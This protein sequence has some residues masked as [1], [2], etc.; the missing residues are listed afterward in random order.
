MLTGCVA[1]PEAKSFARP[2]LR[3]PRSSGTGRQSTPARLSAVGPGLSSK[4]RRSARRAYAINA[5]DTRRGKTVLQSS[6]SPIHSGRGCRG[7]QY[8]M[9]PLPAFDPKAQRATVR[10]ARRLQSRSYQEAADVFSSYVLRELM[11]QVDYWM[12]SGG[13]AGDGFPGSGLFNAGQSRPSPSQQKQAFQADY[14]SLCVYIICRCS[15]RW[16][17]NRNK[18]PNVRALF[19]ATRDIINE[20]GSPALDG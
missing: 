10:P 8:G 2:T 14:G 17:S 15:T 13:V 16:G 1:D 19:L 9:R 7:P 5:A 20:N 11:Q 18:I 4:L 6:E 12:A 3:S